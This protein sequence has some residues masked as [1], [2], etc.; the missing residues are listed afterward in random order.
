MIY[1]YQA[2]P[3]NE[4]VIVND[5]SLIFCS[6]MIQFA[7]KVDIQNCVIREFDIYA[8]CFSSGLLVKNCTLE[9][10]IVWQ[11][12]GHNKKP[13]VFENCKF[14]G[15]VDFEDCC[16]EA[17][18]VMKDVIF[19][20]NSNLLGNKDTPVEVVLTRLPKLENVQGKLNVNT[21]N[22]KTKAKENEE[23]L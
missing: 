6:P 2:D 21:F 15:F 16:F 14:L 12:G 10:S 7:Q 20:K 1:K 23:E 9:C 13:I 18:L 5:E 17:E 22:A 11:S 4:I 3:E 8:S 19:S